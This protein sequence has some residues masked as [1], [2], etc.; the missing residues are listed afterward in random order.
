MDTTKL[1]LEL[2]CLGKAGLALQQNN[3]KLVRRIR[4][5]WHGTETTGAVVCRLTSEPEIFAPVEAFCDNLTP[6][7]PVEFTKCAPRLSFNALSALTERVNGT[8]KAELFAV[9]AEGERALLTSVSRAVEF[10]PH[11]D[12]FG[13]ACV[14][15]LLAA[16]VMPN[17]PALTPLLHRIA[18]LRGERGGTPSLNGYQGKSRDDVLLTV[19]CAYDAILELGITYCEPPPSFGT[20][21]QRIRTAEEILSKKFATCLDLSLLFAALLEA[22]GLHPLLLLPKG[23]CF[24][25]C[26]LQDASL[27]DTITDD[28]QAIR[29][30]VALNE[31]CV[32]ETTLAVKG[33]NRFL[34]AMEATNAELEKDE[35]FEF[36]LDVKQARAVGIRPLSRE[37]DESVV[38]SSEGETPVDEAL[39]QMETADAEDEAVADEPDI[40]P[41]VAK[42][43]SKL[44]DFSRRNRLLNFKDSKQAVKLFFSDLAEAEDGL[45]SNIVYTVNPR[46]ENLTEAAKAGYVEAEWK[47]ERLHADLDEKELKK[48]LLELYRTGKSDLE[49][50]GVNTIFLAAGFLKWRDGTGT[51]AEEYRA[52]LMLIPVQIERKSVQSGFRL[53]RGDDDTTINVTLLEMVKKDFGLAINGLTPPPEDEHGLDVAKILRIF[54][55]AIKTMKGWEVEE[56]LYLA[57][58]SFNKFVMWE[59]LGK[60]LDALRKNPTVNHLIEG[61]GAMDDGVTPVAPNEVD[62]CIPAK[63]LFLPMSADSSQLAAVLSAAKGKNF[64]L[65][66]PPGSGKS[67]TIANLIA[68]CLGI[69]KTVLFVAEKRA[70]LEVVQRRLRRIGLGAFCLELHSNKSGKSDVLAQ[71]RETLDFAGGTA[72]SEWEA[73]VKELEASRDALSAYVTALHNPS[74]CGLTPYRAFSYLLS[75][76]EDERSFGRVGAFAGLTFA[77]G[78]LDAMLEAGRKQVQC[79]IEI[80]P[81]LFD[82]FSFCRADTWSMEWEHRAI[83]AANTL[84]A[85][86]QGFDAALKPLLDLTGIADATPFTGAQYRAFVEIEA[87]LKAAPRFE[88]DTFV[89]WATYAPALRKRCDAANTCIAMRKANPEIDYASVRKLDLPTL[90]QRWRANRQSFVLFRWFKDRALL[91]ELG[92]CLK[93]PSRSP[94]KTVGLSRWFD[95]FEKY[96]DNAS[97]CATPEN[98]EQWKT[99]SAI[100]AAGQTLWD[101]LHAVG[102]KPVNLEP[103]LTGATPLPATEAA[104]AYTA[105]E[106]ALAAFLETTDG[107]AAFGNT[108]PHW[109]DRVSEAASTIRDAHGELRRWCLW[110]A[111]RKDALAHGLSPVVDAAERGDLPFDLVEAAIRKRYCEQYV[112]AVIEKEPV[113]R[114]FLGSAQD[115]LT[116]K[117]GMLDDEVAELAK[118]L[119]VARLAANLPAGRMGVCPATT[120]LGI[121]KR[122]CEKKSRIKP[123]RTLL[124]SIPSLISS[125]KPCFLMSPLSVAQYLPPESKPFD[126]VV[127]DEASQ[128]TVPDAIGVIARGKQCVIV[129]DPHQLPP[130]TFFQRQSEATADETVSDSDIQELESILDECKASG[131]AESYLQWHYRSRH[132]SLIAFSNRHYYGNRLFTFPSAQTGNDALGVQFHFVENGVYDRCKS[133]SNKE[134]AKAV[135]AAVVKRLLDPAFAT[136]STGVVT[137]SEAQQKLIE[138][139]MDDERE[140][141]P[142][143]ERFFDDSLEEPFFVKNLENVQG[144]ERDAIFFSICYAKDKD[145]KFAMNF[146]PLNRA[147]GERRLNVA[148]TR[149][150]E[151]VV[152]FASIHA[153]DIDLSRTQAMGAAHLK[154]F[155]EYA[156]RGVNALG[157]PAGESV[158]DGD[159]FEDEIA[160]FLRFQGYEVE[161][162]VGCSGYRVD[163]AVR[164]KV[165]PDCYA[166]GIEC[167]GANYR[168]AASARDRDKLRRSVLEGLGWRVYRVWTLAWWFDR[169]QAKANLLA[170]VEAAVNG[171]PSPGKAKAVA[172]LPRP[173]AKVASAPEPEPAPGLEDPGSVYVATPVKD[174]SKKASKFNLLE[175]PP[176]LG[177][178]I[179]RI[180]D[181]EG[182]ILESLLRKRILREWGFIR[183]R[184]NMEDVLRRSIPKDLETTQQAAG[185]VFWPPATPSSSYTGYRMQGEEKEA[186]RAIEEIPVQEIRNAARYVMALYKTVSEE[187]LQKETLK[188]LGLVRVTAAAKEALNEAFKGL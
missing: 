69:G 136:K 135:V 27:P 64:V 39:P 106:S 109:F 22:S 184:E 110:N 95:T 177:E 143:I 54:R 133:R 23:H 34:A 165:K 157:I 44:L 176:L 16:F 91:K 100:L 71:F 81:E 48:R 122:E 68:Y 156:E 99:N 88:P 175:G 187:T 137:F 67:Q 179:R 85:A 65:H 182:P 32:F 138:D 97:I 42:W 89:R 30:R 6:E 152:V 168:N 66:G 84:T 46:P 56:D 78:E 17:D 117:F 90:R 141:H 79:G 164:S 98:E 76:S 131:M 158:G 118:R 120:E 25:G 171:K 19:K 151:Q 86:A 2:D 57:R 18:E 58:F 70:A 74:P 52:P 9:P 140:K 148:V 87:T 172:S 101:N 139:L 20:T 183:L 11:D 103:F 8:V 77:A 47:A 119:I 159:R 161:T 105:L 83:D 1:E 130:T 73:T 149:A 113:L 170:E 123:V 50:S 13:T 173:T 132:E 82:A 5:T 180:V 92:L 125:L 186:R 45:E 40:P 38:I 7:T 121:L 163:I 111:C 4:A 72:P 108:E 80:A 147:G 37:R 185:R 145:G 144:D 43:R 112:A 31:I 128:I 154:N 114:E 14:P 55:E 116:E 26:H 35:A 28:L 53:L 155:L 24:V 60:R 3:V 12:W 49:E 178:E 59:D 94:F 167:D 174:Y 33:G 62:T 124:E 166:I 51:R 10:C 153:S 61:G 127:F 15:E 93:D 162:Q 75:H 160:G 146:G 150:K 134:E 96:Q 29:K 188:R 104:E 129:G 115:G 142:E 36:A 21:G 107:K 63:E 102:G 181:T 41:R 169:E 126:L